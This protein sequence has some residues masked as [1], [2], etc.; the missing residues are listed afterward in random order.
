MIILIITRIIKK[1]LKKNERMC[2]DIYQ[3]RKK[4]RNKI[5]MVP[6]FGNKIKYHF[7]IKHHFFF[8]GH[9]YIES[10]TDCCLHLIDTVTNNMADNY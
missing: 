5:G 3:N 1:H 2:R 4:Y 9:P 6:C 7:D 8:P 10:T